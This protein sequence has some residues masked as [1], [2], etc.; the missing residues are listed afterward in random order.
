MS[1]GATARWTGGCSAPA[2]ISAGNGGPRRRRAR[3]LLGGLRFGTLAF[4]SLTAIGCG[5]AYTPSGGALDAEVFPTSVRATAAGWLAAS[6][7]F[8]S[9]VGLAA[10]GVLADALGSFA[11]AAILVCLPAVVLTV[12]YL[13]L[14][15]TRGMELEQSA[16]EPGS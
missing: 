4:G 12:L 16:P 5:A 1:G 7:V 6:G 15:E 9:V 10:F 13:T 14:P 3:R 8:G 2:V 11:G